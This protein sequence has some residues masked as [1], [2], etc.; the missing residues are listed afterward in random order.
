MLRKILLGLL[1]GAVIGVFVF[2][3]V[4]RLHLEWG[5]LVIF[6]A[7]ALVG[8]LVGLVAGKP[9]W[10]R[11][12]KLEASLKSLAGAFMSVTA[13]YGARKWLGGVRVNLEVLGGNSGALGQVPAAA[14]PVIGALLGFVFQIDDALGSDDKISPA[15]VGRGRVVEPDDASADTEDDNEASESRRA[16]RG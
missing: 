2:A 6:G 10:A 4:S 13:L 1:E 7:A 14:L 8:A 9:I 3:L 16:R 11:E 5:A 12:A 15:R